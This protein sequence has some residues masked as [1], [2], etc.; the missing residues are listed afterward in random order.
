MQTG[1]AVRFY[2]VQL[3]VDKLAKFYEFIMNLADFDSG[4]PRIAHGGTSPGGVTQTASGTSMFL[5]Q[6]ARGI[7]GVVSRMDTGITEPSVRAEVYYLI[8]ND[9]EELEKPE[10]GSLNIVA[11]GSSALVV[12]EQSTIRLKEMLNETNNPVDMQI[13]GVEGRREM[14]RG[15]MKSLPLDVD[16]ILPDEF[17]VINK[18][19]GPNALPAPAPQGQLPAPAGAQAPP[20][21]EQGLQPGQ[22][23]PVMPEHKPVPAKKPE[24]T[25]VGSGERAAG[26]DHSQFSQQET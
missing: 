19:A 7:K 9:I 6:S 11:K 24:G 13:I 20:P 4:V 16:R 26:K 14:L 8:D 25:V 21:P 17:D 5:S 12:K 23:A 1:P 22:P 18:I 3:L 15:A 2:N 10:Y